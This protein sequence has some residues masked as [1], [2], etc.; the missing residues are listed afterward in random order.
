MSKPTKLPRWATSGSIVEPN[1]GAK[2]VGYQ[3][4]EAPIAEYDNWRAK[5]THDW[6][7]F[8]A[9]FFSD[10]GPKRI[11]SAAD[12][13]GLKVLVGVE[14]GDVAM[15]G[16]PDRFGFYVA[17]TTAA[18][19]LPPFQFASIGTPGVYWVVLAPGP[20]FFGIPYGLPTLNAAGQVE[21][22]PAAK[23]AP[24]GVAGLDGT[25]SLPDEQFRGVYTGP[26]TISGA[27]V[28]GSFTGDGSALHTLN[29]S[30]LKGGTVPDA[31]LAGTLAKVWGRISI[32]ETSPGVYGPVIDDGSGNFT[33]ALAGTTM[34]VV[35]FDTPRPDARYAVVATARSVG[36][37]VLAGV[38]YETPESFGIELFVGKLT[39]A[40]DLSVS[41]GAGND[42]SFAVF[43]N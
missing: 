37:M 29:A 28:N 14:P 2:D 15:I 31:R 42:V 27:A 32:Q 24:N 6:L 10:G 22:Q 26:V 17:T 34:I 8:L 33:V 13:D 21:Q 1:E 35:T 3:V 39:G 41:G 18:P 11:Q 9:P 43:D 25:G 40:E 23:G 30:E 16:M 36:T 38:G 12:I 5:L 19:E 7:A 20:G 4:G